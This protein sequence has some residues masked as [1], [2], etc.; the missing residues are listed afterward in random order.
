MSENTFSIGDTAKMASVS[1]KQI[2]NWEARGHIPE[3]ERIVYGSRSFRRFTLEQVR[4]ITRIRELVDQGYT[5]PAAAEMAKTENLS[6]G[7]E[8]RPGG[9]A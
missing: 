1:Q 7:K 6:Q 9:L 4:L 5:L 8:S 3:A 2:R